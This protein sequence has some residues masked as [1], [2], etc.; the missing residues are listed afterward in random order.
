MKQVLSFINLIN[1]SRRP[2]FFTGAGISTESG[3]PDFRGPSGFWKTNTPIYFKDFI[4]SESARRDSWQRNINL[5]KKLSKVK[6]NDGHLALKDIMERN[7]KSYLITQ[8]V[9]NLHQDSG[10]PKEKIVELHGNSTY[11]NCLSCYKKYS[12]KIVHE[13]FIKKGLIIPCDDCGGLLKTATISFGQ[14]MPEEEM[15][16]ALLKAVKADLFVVIGSSLAV[17][18]AAGLPKIAQDS[19]SKLVILN[20]EPTELD[21]IFDLVVHQKIGIFLKKVVK[22]I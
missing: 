16:I 22:N 11:A 17:Y 10:V 19:G 9:D 12:L 8:N 6:P 4:S 20:A 21:S 7:K 2:L 18:P 1:N 3:I 5:S 14:P 13:P 15:E